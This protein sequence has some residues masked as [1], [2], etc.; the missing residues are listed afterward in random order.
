MA[1]HMIHL[2]EHFSYT[3]Q[4]QNGRSQYTCVAACLSAIAQ[5][6]YPGRWQSPIALMH[7]IYTTYAGQDIPSNEQG[8]T[9]DE[10]MNWLHSVTIGAIDMN[11]LISNKALLRAELDAQNKQNVCQLITIADESKLRYARSLSERLHNWADKGLSHAI[12]RVGYSDSSG[13]AYFEEPAAGLAFPH[14]LPIL[15]SDI[16]AAGI[17]TCLATMPHSVSVPPVDFSFQKGVWP[18]P[19]LVVDVN[20]AIA[21]TRAL[22]AANKDK[23]QDV[24]FAKALHELGVSA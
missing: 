22:R 20:Q 24:L 7:D 15:W 12:L 13:V 19:K 3:Y 9:H 21:T 1:D 17:Q 23:T 18:A 5:I 2:P 11:H 8:M 14:P 4:F 16:E 10:A 6:S